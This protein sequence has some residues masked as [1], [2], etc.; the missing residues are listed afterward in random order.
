[1]ERFA[2]PQDMWYLFAFVV[3]TTMAWLW[4]LLKGVVQTQDKIVRTME[5]HLQEISRHMASTNTALQVIIDRLLEVAV[6]K[7]K[8]TRKGGEK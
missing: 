8:R 6:G 5:N 2:I 7:A 1:M 3:I 4:Y